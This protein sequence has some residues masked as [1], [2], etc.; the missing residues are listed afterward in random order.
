MRKAASFWAALLLG[1]TAMAANFTGTWN[2]NLKKSTGDI[3]NIASYKVQIEEIG[4]NTYRTTLDVVETSGKKI[5]Q[6]VDRIY[7]G[8][9]RHVPI[10][11]HMYK[12]TEISEFTETG[13][14][15]ITMKEDGKVVEV[16]LSSVS[17]DGKTM[18]NR[19]TTDK[20]ETVFV[21]EKE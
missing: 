1:G 8:K 15:K 6:E 3:G 16:L 18:T 14:R 2:A 13:G 19:E 7:D 10:N 21:L 9:E 17:K 5:H 12:G 11:G 20:G 4:P